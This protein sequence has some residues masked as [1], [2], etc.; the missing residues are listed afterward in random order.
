MKYLLDTCALIWLVNG[1]S[2]PSPEAVRLC[3][4]VESQLFVSAASAWE[5]ALKAARCKLSLSLPPEAW[6]RR[7][8]RQHSLEELPVT[9]RIAIAAAALEA[10]HNDPFDRILIA[11]AAEHDMRILSPDRVIG[12]Y[13]TVGVVW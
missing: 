11:T 12:R 7:A 1:D 6:W 3:A 4:D 10:I 9:S 5:I 2:Q 8:L 13:R